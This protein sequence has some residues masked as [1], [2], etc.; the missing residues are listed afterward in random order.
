VVDDANLQQ[1][2]K[3]SSGMNKRDEFIGIVKN[4]MKNLNSQ[5]LMDLIE[6]GI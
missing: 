3:K 6:F 1:T 2:K 5:D 4:S